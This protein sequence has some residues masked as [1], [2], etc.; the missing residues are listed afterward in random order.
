MC[1]ATTSGDPVYWSR[2]GVN[3]TSANEADP[4]FVPH[5]FDPSEKRPDDDENT[6]ENQTGHNNDDHDVLDNWRHSDHESDYAD[7]SAANWP[8]NRLNITAV[9]RSDTGNYTCNRADGTW[10][11]FRVQAVQPA[12][13]GAH[14]A[15]VVR[16]RISQSVQFFCLF[17]AFPLDGLNASGI[18][19]WHKEDDASGPADN[20]A[21][22][23]S[24]AVASLAERTQIVHVN[25]TWVNV[26]LDILDVSKKDNGSYVCSMQSPLQPQRAVVTATSSL[27]VLDVPQVSVDHVKAVGASKI[28][29]NWTINDGNDPVKQY[30]VKW[31]K[32]NSSSFTFYHHP[33]GG[34]NVSYVLDG[35]EPSTGYQIQINAGNS[36]GD[37][38]MYTYSPIV[39]TLASDPVFIPKIDVKGNTHST[40][41]IGWA[42]PP[43]DVLEY[44]NSYEVVVADTDP[45]STVIQEALHEQNGRNLPYMFDNLRTATSYR[46]RVRSCND[47]T[48]LCGNWSEVVNGTTMDGTASAPLNLRVQCSFYNISGRT[49][50]SATWER[51]ERPNGNITLYNI[52][53]DGM[54]TYRNHHVRR[55]ETFGPKVKSIDRNLFKADYENVPPNTN[56]TVKVSGMTRSKRPGD[57]AAASCSMRPTVPE[58]VERSMWGKVQTETGSWVLKLLLQPVSERNGPICGYRVYLVRL[59]KHVGRHIGRPDSLP[60]MSYREAHA[61][62][63][64]KGGAYIAEILSRDAFQ[65]ELFVGDGQRVR[66]NET[67]LAQEPNASCRKLLGGHYERK[68]AVPATK[69][70]TSTTSTSTESAAGADAGAGD[71][72]EL[73]E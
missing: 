17:E 31:K 62:N 71:D 26:T 52:V 21:S 18:I 29:L 1:R 11:S 30:Y 34:G 66:M 37:G 9:R 40:I 6:D 68:A 23:K 14:S 20:A 50:V 45:N 22:P 27:L 24:A 39:R 36:I 4:R 42:P 63:N 33:I 13:L 16:T 70:T 49:T 69:T 35:F 10:T 7:N 28:F 65:G 73:G 46:F 72:D 32:E 8:Q 59:G 38:P 2:N 56:Y 15:R 12:R 58:A 48:K 44:V 64:S 25:E 3:I 67:V 61:A 41:T 55:I 53:L 54:A 19:R 47:L 43:A 5:R 57:V 51:P 60:I